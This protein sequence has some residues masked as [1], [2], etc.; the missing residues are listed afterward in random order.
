MGSS[1]IVRWT[2]PVGLA[3]LGVA[4]AASQAKPQAAIGDVVP[5]YEFREFLAGGDGRRKVSEL[6][7][8][9]VLVVNWTDTDFGRGASQEAEKVVEE[10][11]PEGLIVILLETH[12]MKPI[13]LE[14]A[15]MRLYPGSPA[16]LAPN[17]KPPIQYL[18]NGPPPNIALIGV[19][20]K[21]L[22]AGS[23]TAD[24]GKASKLAKEELKRMTG[25]WG[26]NETAKQARALAFGEQRLAEAKA[27]VD[28]AL[29]AEPSQ[30][31][32]LEVQGELAVRRASWEASARHLL[33]A[34][35][36]LQALEAARALAAATRGAAEWEA[37]AASLLQEL[38]GEQ[39]TRESELDG[40]LA[41]LLKPLAKKP[42]KA[43]DATKLRAFGEGEAAGT[44]V[45][46]RALHL[47][48][49]AAA[50]AEK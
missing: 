42:P 31:E 2:F 47:A 17:Q 28:A 43:A 29:A 1:R 25:G 5:D 10:L 50:A 13:D 9:P 44:R 11:C 20:G 40:Q 22:I 7:G 41:K 14:A 12:N 19:D 24:F 39:V 16:W 15:A 38:S 33:A 45:G 34:G 18:E 36:T 6:R 27:L 3:A 23:Y 8:Q 30:A 49:V 4:S 37:S 48:Q 32:L 46:T 35:R 26:E 21:L